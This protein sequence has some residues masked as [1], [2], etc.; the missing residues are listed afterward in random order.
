MIKVRF[1]FVSNFLLFDIIRGLV[2]HRSLLQK[3]HNEES[4]HG[5]F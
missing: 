1:P 4:G 2:V 3:L 5:G